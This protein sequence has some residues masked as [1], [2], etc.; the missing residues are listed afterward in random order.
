[1][2]HSLSQQCITTVCVPISCADALL[3]SHAIPGVWQPVP[4]GQIN[5][6]CLIVQEQH[7]LAESL[8][9]SRESELKELKVGP[10]SR[11]AVRS[12]AN[13]I[14]GLPRRQGCTSCLCGAAA[15]ASG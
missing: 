13:P 9:N 1:M 2:M 3:I 4:D 7:A 15:V 5:L 8:A 12:H 11:A 6:L 14:A 10:W